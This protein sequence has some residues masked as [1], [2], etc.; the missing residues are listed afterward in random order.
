MSDPYLT[1]QRQIQALHEIL[2]PLRKADAGPISDVYDPTY[3]GLTTPGTTTYGGQDGVWTR[4]GNMVTVWGRVIWT[5]AT[6]TGIALVSLPIAAV[7][8][9]ISRYPVYLY[10]VNVT[11]A[12]GGIVGAIDTGTS[13][14]G[15]VMNSPATN[16]AGTLVTVEVAGD[17]TFAC[18]Y[19]VA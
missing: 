1:I 2:E 17:L 19:E 5:N 15:F 3:I 4:T 11:F 9:R 13:A 18:S 7:F 8:T 16:A 10:P 14:L 12:N 6:G